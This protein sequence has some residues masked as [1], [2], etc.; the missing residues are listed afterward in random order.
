MPTKDSTASWILNMM[1][2]PSTNIIKRCE[3]FHKTPISIQHWTT[4]KLTQFQASTTNVRITVHS[5]STCAHD[6]RDST[7]PMSQLAFSHKNGTKLVR[8]KSN[9]MEV[10][11]HNFCM[12]NRK[13]VNRGGASRGSTI[14]RALSRSRHIRKRSP[15]KVLIN[16]QKI[17]SSD[18]KI[19]MLVLF[20]SCSTVF[21]DDRKN[22]K[23]YYCCDNPIERSTNQT[24]NTAR[25]CNRHSH[26]TSILDK[27]NE[28][29]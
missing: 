22:D 25:S 5:S 24:T 19:M 10:T 26:S 18:G 23:D 27:P 13:Q 7:H 15:D 8:P 9:D 12:T 17:A 11:V 16:H 20:G 2:G 29:E 4:T 6:K 21:C 1:L 3:I 28:A 14:H